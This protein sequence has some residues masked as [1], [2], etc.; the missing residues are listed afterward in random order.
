MMTFL[1]AGFGKSVITPRVGAKLIGYF[2]RPGVSTGI[3][4]DLYARS[5]IITSGDRTV[6]LCSVELLWLWSSFVEQVRQAVVARCGLQ[7]E[8]I[9]IF[10]THTHS[11]P[12]PFN[13]A[14]WDAPLVERIA[15]A[16]VAA[17]NS[18]QAARLQFGF[19]QLQGYNIN[20]RWLNRPADPSVAVMRVDT[21]NG[22]PLALLGNYAC[23]AVV[24]GYDNLLISADWPGYAS[25]LLE[26]E[27]VARGGQDCVALFS[28]GGAGDVNP[29]SETVRQRLEAGHPVG[30][31]GSLTSYYGPFDVGLPDS[32]NIEDRAGG[33]FF[34]AETI[35]RAYAAEVLRVWRRIEPTETAPLWL[36]HITVEGGVGPDEP[37][38]EGLTAD[39][40]DIIPPN[41][42]GTVPLEIM[43]LGIGGAVLV[44]Q[45]GEVFSETAVEFR[46]LSQQMGYGFPILVS[47][48]NGSYAYMPPA[49]AFDEGGYEVVW[50]R[51][52]GLSRHLQDRVATA[53][54]PILRRHAP[55]R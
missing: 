24:M 26:A 2:N 48:A 13:E 33:T 5:L 42:T 50:A 43:L 53:I 52:Y 36:E 15:D 44:S 3:H 31:I 21:I 35:G 17:Y 40:S 32:W 45:P 1:Q 47:Y 51:R 7:A 16:I 14:D 12:S 28:Q 38:A 10:C 6:A 49:N 19:G 11:G 20:R 18:Q 27:L 9:F 22:R 30:T 29:L 46:K 55:R 23:H 39:Y 25:R 34:E 8:N 37:P 4:D 54:L 41:T